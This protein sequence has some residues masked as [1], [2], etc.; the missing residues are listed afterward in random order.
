MNSGFP[1][2]AFGWLFFFAC[3]ALQDVFVRRTV[4]N[5]KAGYLHLVFLWLALLFA[6]PYSSH[7][8][9]ASAMYRVSLGHNT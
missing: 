1:L 5:E 3:T 4:G 9:S 6:I 2:A 7:P 8:I